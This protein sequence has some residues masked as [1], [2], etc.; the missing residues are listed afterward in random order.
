MGRGFY[1]W[2][3]YPARSVPVRFPC[4]WQQ[5]NAVTWSTGKR[6]KPADADNAARMRI[7]IITRQIFL[8]ITRQVPKKGVDKRISLMVQWSCSRDADSP[9][10][11]WIQQEVL[12]V[13]AVTDNA[14]A[15]L[16]VELTGAP[17]AMHRRSRSAG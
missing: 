15:Y 7:S 14:A 16:G 9:R 10:L 3:L 6:G 2:E 5:H 11:G 4:A 13:A 1:L 8:K 12:S 17:I